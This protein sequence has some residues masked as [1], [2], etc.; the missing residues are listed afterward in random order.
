MLVRLSGYDKDVSRN[1]RCL[2]LDTKYIERLKSSTYIYIKYVEI[3]IKHDF[4]KKN[5]N[6]L[7]ETFDISQMYV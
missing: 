1:K 5:K 6:F 4:D 3:D 2:V 7:N